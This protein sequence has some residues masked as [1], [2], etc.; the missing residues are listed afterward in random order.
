MSIDRMSGNAIRSDSDITMALESE[1]ESST[2]QD[3]R[4]EHLERKRRAF[5]DD[6][7]DD[8]K[9]SGCLS[10]SFDRALQ[11]VHNDAAAIVCLWTGV[12]S[13]VESRCG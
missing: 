12:G 3:E 8:E 9:E 11:S 2:N 5:H 6:D 1:D 4:D 7:G 13:C 10:L